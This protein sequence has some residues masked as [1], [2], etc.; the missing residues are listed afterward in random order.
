MS[1]P[2]RKAK[3][4]PG[5]SRKASLA[6]DRRNEILGLTMMG[7]ATL[8]VLA[9]VTFSPADNAVARQMSWGTLVRPPGGVEN[10]VGPVG[11][12]LGYVFIDGFL[13]YVSLLFGALLAAWGYVLFRH[14][15]T[16][17]LPFVTILTLLL[18]FQV[19]GLIGW[20]A[21]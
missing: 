7:V 17:F 10:L 20:F 21:S 18:S 9:L 11:A 3:S 8:Y 2:R 15:K 19:A 4:T 14:R 12:W 6:A 5:T 16:V 13:G 1:T